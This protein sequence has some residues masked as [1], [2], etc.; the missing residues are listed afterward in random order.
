MAVDPS[1]SAFEPMRHGLRFFG[2][3]RPGRTAEADV[4]SVRALDRVFQVGVADDRKSRPELLLVDDA[5]AIGHVRDDR[6]RIEETGTGRRFAA[7]Q[8]PRAVPLGV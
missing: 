5:H 4:E 2:I 3:G 7:A 8:D 6:Y 1:R